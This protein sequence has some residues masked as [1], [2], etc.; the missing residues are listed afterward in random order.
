MKLYAHPASTT[1]RPVL[2]FC[3]HENVDVE[4][5]TVDLFTGAH[6][7]ED[8]LK[9]NPNALVPVLD[10]DG[11]IL[12]ESSAILKY[13]A[14]KLNSAAYPKDLQK[15]ARINEIM[16]WFN[17]QFYREFGYHMIYPQV[18]PAHKRPTDEAT[19]SIV[20]WGLEQSKKALAILDGRW[21][22]LASGGPY[23]LGDDMTIADFFG[24]EFVAFGDIVKC[25]LNGYPNVA[26]WINTM[27]SHA[28]WDEVNGP[29]NGFAQS[30]ADQAFVAVA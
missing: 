30:I 24:A 20:N 23:L 17:T 28:A 11:F 13:L 27:K 25:D 15:R 14:D 4:H 10:D 26:R 22:M 5:V 16:D 9:I 8:Y 3:A 18:F 2:L 19:Q 6:F 29:I 12:T 7:Q 1:S 21:H